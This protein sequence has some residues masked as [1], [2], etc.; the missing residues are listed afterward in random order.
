MNPTSEKDA[1]A[2]ADLV[3]VQRVKK[4]ENDETTKYYYSGSATLFTANADNWLL[5]ENILD[6]S[7]GIIASARFDDGLPGID[8]PY[9]DKYFFYHYLSI[10]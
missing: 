9:A 3:N 5:T 8:N 10:K 7:G 4:V 6:L 2:A 1:V